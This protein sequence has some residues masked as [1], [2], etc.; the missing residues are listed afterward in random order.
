MD[1]LYTGGVK[2]PNCGVAAAAGAPDCAACGVIFAK[3]LA[4]REREKKEAA[5]F[6][7]LSQAPV[8]APPKLWRGRVAAGVLLL[9]WFAGLMWYYANRLNA[10]EERVQAELRARSRAA[11]PAVPPR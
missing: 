1:F 5:E 10:R 11:A 9:I 8:A 7:A 4:Q 3:Y 6:L 2:C